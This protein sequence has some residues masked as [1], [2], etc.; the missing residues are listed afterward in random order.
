[1][2]AGVAPA[3]SVLTTSHSDSGWLGCGQS[4]TQHSS[5]MPRWSRGHT[6]EFFEEFV[7]RHRAPLRSELRRF[8]A[9][10]RDE[11]GVFFEWQRQAIPA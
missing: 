8:E 11:G 9:T 1:M 4:M 3:G 6:G 5:V 7:V 2:P 10:G